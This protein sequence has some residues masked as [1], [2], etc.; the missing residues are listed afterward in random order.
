MI[1]AANGPNYAI[2]LTQTLNR[3]LFGF[4][5]VEI[6]GYKKKKN[7]DRET[8]V[9]TAALKSTG[10]AL[11]HLYFFVVVYKLL[12]LFLTFSVLV[13]N[14]RK[15]LYT[16]VNPTRDLLNRDIYVFMHNNHVW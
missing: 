2:L 6:L 1:I 4:V 3:T 15:L 5:T 10:I 7:G 11:L 9:F 14:P 16:V 12:L 13:A 8:I